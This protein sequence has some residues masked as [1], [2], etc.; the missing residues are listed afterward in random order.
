MTAT[1]TKATYTHGETVTLQATP[2]TGYHFTSWSGDLSGSTNPAT[3]TMDGNKTVTAG[4]A[5]NTY[6][7]MVNATNGSVIATP[8][9]STYNHGE[10]VTLQATPN[11]GYSFTG[12]SGDLTGMGNPATLAMDGDKTV[13]ANFT[14]IQWTLTVSASSGGS[15]TTPNQGAFRYTHGSS[16]PMVATAAANYHFTGWTGPA[17]RSSLARWRILLRQIRA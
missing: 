16:V 2:N 6:T 17:A 9:K 8:S 14:L 13:T 4:F 1:P 11:T 5:I 10:T 12:W 3:I 15:V 7:L